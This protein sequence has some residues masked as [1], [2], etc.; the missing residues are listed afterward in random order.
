MT[1]TAAIDLTFK[2]FADPTR[3]RILHL[4][5]Q[6]AL[7]VCDLQ[8]VLKTHQ[9]KISRHLAYLRRARL[10]DSRKQGPWV[11]YSLNREGGK[12][13]AAL[14]NCLKTCFK[15]TPTLKA[16]LA[17]LAKLKTKKACG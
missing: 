4:L 14:I 7:C 12:Y 1:D 9:P 13:K 11:H 5:G 15:E 6:G 8:G 3:L 10:V 2:A 17:S 16:D